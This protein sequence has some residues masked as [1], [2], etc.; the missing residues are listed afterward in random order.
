MRRRE[1]LLAL[2]SGLAGPL[3]S[4]LSHAQQPARPTPKVY[5]IGV[6]EATAM[7]SNR[8]NFEALRD[9]LRDLGYVEDKNIVIDYRSADGRSERFPELTAELVKAQTDIIVVR[10]TPAALA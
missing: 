6:L 3:L 1:L 10:G 7:S 5:R 8:A 2:G 9:G 4:P